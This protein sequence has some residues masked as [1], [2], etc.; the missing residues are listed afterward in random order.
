MINISF[1]QGL[2]LVSYMFSVSAL[3]LGS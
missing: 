2:F 3:L 1:E